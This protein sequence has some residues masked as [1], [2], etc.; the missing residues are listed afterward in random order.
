MKEQKTPE[1]KKKEEPP[2]KTESAPKSVTI[3]PHDNSKLKTFDGKPLLL[4]QIEI[5]KQLSTDH[6][7]CKLHRSRVKGMCVNCIKKSYKPGEKPALEKIRTY[8]PACQSGPWICEPCF[9]E[10]H[11]LKTK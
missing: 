7:F 6:A 2:K 10:V 5:L 11:D 3:V 4:N 9:D 1:K 8:C